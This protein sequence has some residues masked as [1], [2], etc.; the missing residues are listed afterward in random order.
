M[1][2]GGEMLEYGWEEYGKLNRLYRFNR[3][4]YI[5]SSYGNYMTIPVKLVKLVKKMI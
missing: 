2:G 4:L 5:A 1:T 3:L